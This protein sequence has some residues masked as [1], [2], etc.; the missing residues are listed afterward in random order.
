[1]GD[2]FNELKAQSS[3]IEKVIK[4]EE[5]TFLKTLDKGIQKFDAYVKEGHQAV[6]GKFAFELYDTFGF[7]IDLTQLMAEEQ[8]LTVVM[9]DFTAALEEQKN[10]SRK[11]AEMDKEIGHSSMTLQQLILLVMINWR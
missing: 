5:Q 2:A 1:M 8:N 10:R 3:L 6:T 9:S 4:E 11:A 7:P